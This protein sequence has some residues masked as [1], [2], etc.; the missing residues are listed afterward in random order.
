MSLFID[1][2]KIMAGAYDKVHNDFGLGGVFYWAI[3]TG[4]SRLRR[5]VAEKVTKKR[6]SEFSK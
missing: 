2:V 4:K 5:N 1:R 3:T 6:N